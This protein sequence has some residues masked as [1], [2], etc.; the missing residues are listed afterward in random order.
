MQSFADGCDRALDYAASRVSGLDLALSVLADGET[1]PRVRRVWDAVIR[2]VSSIQWLLGDP[3]QPYP[4][5]T[6]QLGADN[7]R[8]A[9]GGG[10]T[11]YCVA[12]PNSASTPFKRPSRMPRQTV[13]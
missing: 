10:P 4:T 8:L 6:W 9:F 3:A 7:L 2:N 12:Q 5:T 13:S 1:G 11:S